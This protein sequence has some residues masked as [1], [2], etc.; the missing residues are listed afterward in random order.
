[1]KKKMILYFLFLNF[2]SQRALKDIFACKILKVSHDS[3]L[4]KMTEYF[5]F[6]Q[7]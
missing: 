2:I 1:M 7:K 5:P 4:Y 3:K 6:W